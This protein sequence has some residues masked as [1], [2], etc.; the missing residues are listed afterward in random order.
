M[1]ISLQMLNPNQNLF[2]AAIMQSGAQ[3]SLP[4]GKPSLWQETYDETCKAAGCPV[5]AGSLDCLKGLSADKLMAASVAMKK[6][7]KYDSSFPWGPSIDGDLIP[8]APYKLLQEGK[9]SKVPF[10]TGQNL[11]EGTYFVPTTITDVPGFIN[12]V[13]PSPVDNATMDKILQ[14][15]PDDPALGSPFGTG[16]ELFGLNKA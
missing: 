9:F 15:Y 2:R 10:I 12:T 13:V 3:N 14:A 1:S 16:N 11:D 4:L 7:P 5:G 8:D 6:L